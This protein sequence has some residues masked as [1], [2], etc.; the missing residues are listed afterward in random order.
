MEDGRKRRAG[1]KEGLIWTQVSRQSGWGEK[2][3][4]ISTGENR[5]SKR[6]RGEKVKSL[7]NLADES[8][9]K[10]QR[11]STKQLTPCPEKTGYRAVKEKASE[12][13]CP[14]VDHAA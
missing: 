2:E 5:K 7:F 9:K 13:L 12:L 1:E 6:A 8:K 3:E 4:K 11:K 14:S 10:T